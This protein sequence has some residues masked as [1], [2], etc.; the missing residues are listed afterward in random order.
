MFCCIARR[1]RAQH[2]LEGFGDF[3]YT[4]SNAVKPREVKY[5]LPSLGYYNLNGKAIWK[6]DRKKGGGGNK[7][8]RQKKENE[9]MLG[10]N[11][12][13]LKENVTS[14]ITTRKIALFYGSTWG[15][16]V[17]KYK[18]FVPFL[19]LPY[20]LTEQIWRLHLRATKS[21]V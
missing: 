20:A 10:R 6:T 19:S 13:G 9:Y 4:T 3:K 11:K 14:K 1:N 18:F 8:Y 21:D 16:N 5:R 2:V 15:T 7:K 17:N 12:E